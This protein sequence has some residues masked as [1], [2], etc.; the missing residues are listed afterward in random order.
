VLSLT[1]NKKTAADIGSA[2]AIAEAYDVASA[3]VRRYPAV[4]TRR[5]N[6]WTKRFRKMAADAYTEQAITKPKAKNSRK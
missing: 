4:F 5:G 2:S 6:D 3:V 1:E